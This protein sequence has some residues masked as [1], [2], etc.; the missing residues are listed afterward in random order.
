V[1]RITVDVTMSIN[2]CPYFPHFLINLGKRFGTEGLHVIELSIC[3]I[4]DSRY[5]ASLIL[6]KGINECSSPVLSTYCST[7]WA[8]FGT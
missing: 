3:G 4:R 7:I 5:R 6:L 8:E 2:V 1:E